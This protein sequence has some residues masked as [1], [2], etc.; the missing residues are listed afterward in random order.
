MA[1]YRDPYNSKYCKAVKCSKR[2]GNQCTEDA[3]IRN[4]NEKRAIYFTKYEVLA[5]GDV[6]EKEIVDE[7]LEL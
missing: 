7:E 2:H 5:H 1:Q 3:C 4:G 6:P